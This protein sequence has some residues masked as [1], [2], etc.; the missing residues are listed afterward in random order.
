MLSINSTEAQNNFDDIGA[1]TSTGFTVSNVNAQWNAANK[2][3]I[4]YAH[5]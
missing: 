5:A 4:Y 2:K 1:P 3:Y